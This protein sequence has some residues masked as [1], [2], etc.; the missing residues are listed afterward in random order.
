MS[1]E[2]QAIPL[3]PLTSLEAEALGEPGHR[4]FRIRAQAEEAAA[5]LWLEKEQLQALA[6]A[7]EQLLAQLAK[8]PESE[9]PPST[10]V[11]REPMSVEL[12]VGR[13]ALGY[14]EESDLVALLV[15]SLEADPDGPATLVC[16]ANRPQ[17]RALSRQIIEVCAAGRPRCPLC[18]DPINPDG[19]HCVRLN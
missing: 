14:V 10:D 19:H 16:L 2:E 3:G 6:V 9:S 7:I 8:S 4:T 15:H 5:M 18:N 12:T 11:A 1:M 17:F 13:L